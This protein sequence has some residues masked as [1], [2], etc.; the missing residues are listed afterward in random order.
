MSER[1]QGWWKARVQFPGEPPVELIPHLTDDPDT[2]REMLGKTYAAA[3]RIDFWEVDRYGNALQ[4]GPEAA[5]A[6]KAEEPEQ[7]DL[8]TEEEKAKRP[9]GMGQLFT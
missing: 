6:G 5:E 2:Y 3:E 1:R 4:P 8:P 7:P 9:P